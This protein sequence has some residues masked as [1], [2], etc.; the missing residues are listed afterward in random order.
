MPVAH[1][2]TSGDA[3]EHLENVPVPAVRTRIC[4]NRTLP[5]WVVSDE[6]RWMNCN[7]QTCCLA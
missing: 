3:V 4:L 5:G 7:Q 1:P 6:V 2:L